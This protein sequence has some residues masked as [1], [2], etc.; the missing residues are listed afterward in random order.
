MG[1]ADGGSAIRTK[2]GD[3][4]A[5]SGTCSARNALRRRLRRKIMHQHSVTPERPASRVP[6]FFWIT[7]ALLAM[8]LVGG[9][10]AALLLVFEADNIN[11]S[12][13][14]GWLLVVGIYVVAITVVCFACT[15]CTAVSILRRE[16]HRRLSIAIL[17]ISSL[18]VLGFGP[19]LV[20]AINGLRR[21]HDEAN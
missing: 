15:V 6:V 19:K 7:V 10:A 5:G 12:G 18:V 8:L 14:W 17:I 4:P 3:R 20:G 1:R 2:L 21:Q 9:A 11:R 13:G 16:P